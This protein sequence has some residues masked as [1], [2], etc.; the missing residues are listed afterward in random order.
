LTHLLPGNYRALL[1]RIRL[2]RDGV[3]FDRHL[4]LYLANLHR[5]VN[6]S[7]VVDI[8]DDTIRLHDAES[9]GFGADIVMPDGQ[10]GRHVLTGIVRRTAPDRTGFDTGDGDRHVRQGGATRV[11]NGSDNRGFLAECVKRE[12]KEEGA[13]HREAQILHGTNLHRAN[14]D[15]SE[16]RRARIHTTSDD[17][18]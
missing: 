4:L 5:E 10:A 7:A 18:V 3:G 2:D 12:G 6:T 9:R 11:G 1:T 8:Q 16:L 15:V 17:V 13:K 14:K